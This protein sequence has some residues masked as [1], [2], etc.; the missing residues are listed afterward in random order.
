MSGRTPKKRRSQKA[1]APPRSAEFPWI[2]ADLR[3]LAEPLEAILP[4]PKNA[5]T[6]DE[7]NLRAIVASLRQFGQR[8]PIVVN[9]RG[10]CRAGVF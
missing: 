9:R 4:D 6:H 10:G 8:K 5:R 7:N 1:P 3:P 2:A